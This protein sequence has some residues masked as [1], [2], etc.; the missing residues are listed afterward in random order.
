MSLLYENFLRNTHSANIQEW[1]EDLKKLLSE[2]ETI[3]DPDPADIQLAFHLKSVIENF[4]LMNSNLIERRRD[5]NK[6]VNDLYKDR[7][8]GSSVL[9]D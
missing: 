7:A 1:F 9:F 3:D 8:S 2:I 4:E 5:K 6:G